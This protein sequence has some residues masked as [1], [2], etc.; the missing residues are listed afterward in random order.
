MVVPLPERAVSGTMLFGKLP[1]HG[2]FVARGVGAGE[3]EALDDWLS[4]SM[5]DART[6]YGDGFDALY[7]CAPPW[8]FATSSD[9]GWQAGVVV[10]SIDA[11]GRRYPLLLAA[12]GTED[13]CRISVAAQCAALVYG[14]FEQG[15]NAD[16]LADALATRV[17]TATS[18]DTSDCSGGSTLA[19]GQWW[20]EGDDGL[21]PVEMHGARPPGL[22][23][24]M[25]TSAGDQ[26]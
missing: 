26:A 25:L 6:A 2:D 11:A 21:V 13:S 17:R 15:W 19:D 8:H 9:D 22:I 24:G 1:T 14:A 3:R 12:S 10:A 7:D 18:A 4:G 16:A 23:R 20:M 5:A